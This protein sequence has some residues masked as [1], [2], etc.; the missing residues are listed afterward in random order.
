MLRSA[1]LEKGKGE[2]MIRW[3]FVASL[4]AADLSA[5]ITAH[6]A[7]LAGYRPVPINNG[8]NTLHMAGHEVLA[9]RAWRE[10]Y[11]AHGF[12][13]VT[14]YMKG[15]GDQ[16]QDLWNLL[17]AFDETGGDMQEHDQLGVSGGAD[18]KLKDFRLLLS[19]D[20]KSAELIIADR[21][22]GQS[23]AD[24][25]AVH[26]HYYRLAQNKDGTIGWPPFYFELHK[27]VTPK[28]AYCDVND[29]FDQE[30]HLGTSSGQGGPGVS[31]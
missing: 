23:Y 28:K 14:L 30:L 7:D 1:A 5:S 9:F 20:G 22:M 10:N 16:G 17:P 18:C 29:A 26:F 15:K 31:G 21:D 8:P 27:T 11:N 6:A 19:P 3:I 13:E 12:D 2:R 24:A 4:L 25:A